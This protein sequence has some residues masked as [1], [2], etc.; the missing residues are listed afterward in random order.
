LFIS[1]ADG[2]AAPIDSR[3]V[4]GFHVR[5]WSGDGMSFWAISDLNDRELTEFVNAIIGR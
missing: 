2:A 1:P 4:R 5:H 3:T